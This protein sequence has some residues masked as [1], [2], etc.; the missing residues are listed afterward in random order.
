MNGAAV[1][2]AIYRLYAAEDIY[3]AAEKFYTKNALVSEGKTNAEGQIQF[4]ELLP[5]KYYI[6]REY[7]SSG[8]SVGHSVL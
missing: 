7:G 4:Q 3:T 5:G 8:V 2:G 1:A 6:K